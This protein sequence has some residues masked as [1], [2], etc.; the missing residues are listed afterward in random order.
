MLSFSLTSRCAGE[1]PANYAR[2]AFAHM[3]D[4]E[5]Q[6]GSKDWRPFGGG[7]ALYSASEQ[8]LAY[9]NTDQM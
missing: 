1:T 4:L 8:M 7:K 2:R 5:E 3:E 9:V 6:Y